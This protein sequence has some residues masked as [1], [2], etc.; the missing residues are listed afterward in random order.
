MT[1]PPLLMLAA[2]LATLPPTALAQGWS[3]TGAAGA[4][5]MQTRGD[6]A[7]LAAAR[8]AEWVRNHDRR[9]F[10]ERRIVLEPTP[11]AGPRSRAV[12]DVDLRPKDAWLGDDGFRVSPSGVAYRQRF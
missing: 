6:G 2:V 1:R 10:G 12:L 4:P 8:V 7:T 11:D 9:A 3:A 5:A